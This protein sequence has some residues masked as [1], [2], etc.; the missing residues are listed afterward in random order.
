MVQ[1][2]RRNLCTDFS[3]WG[4]SRFFSQYSKGAA[5]F[6]MKS[7]KRKLLYALSPS[8]LHKH[9]WC[10][11]MTYTA[12]LTHRMSITYSIIHTATC[13]RA[14][15]AYGGGCQTAHNATVDLHKSRVL[16]DSKSVALTYVHKAK[17]MK[18]SAIS[19]HE[20]L[21]I[22]LMCAKRETYQNHSMFVFHL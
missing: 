14:R 5:T 20:T 1:T 6:L 8:K 15:Y 17:C 10:F 2:C 19:V 7:D 12:T 22:C 11:K 3:T 16:V 18:S 21:C 13:A 4:S 9:L